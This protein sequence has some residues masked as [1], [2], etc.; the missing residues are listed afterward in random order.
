MRND[1]WV[2][3]GPHIAGEGEWISRLV[4][5]A[6]HHS[7][8]I[9]HHSNDE[10]VS[11]LSHHSS[12]IIP[13]S[14]R[15]ARTLECLVRILGVDPGSITTGFGVID[16]ERGRISLVEQGTIGTPRGAELADRLCR[17]HDG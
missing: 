7:S 12:V 4:S 16:Y 2:L 6:I 17:I 1:E 14:P 10:W 9:S 3:Q 13:P 15:P 8:V 11:T 5:L